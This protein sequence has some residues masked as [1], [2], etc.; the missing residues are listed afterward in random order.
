MAADRLIR[1]PDCSSAAI[2]NSIVCQGALPVKTLNRE[3]C[4]DPAGARERRR[5]DPGIEAEF[6]LRWA[7]NCIRSFTGENPLGLEHGCPLLCGD[8]AIFEI[9]ASQLRR[10]TSGVPARGMSMT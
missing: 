9:R 6:G 3:F 8:I 2:P 4:V 5:L 7:I 10:L 1:C